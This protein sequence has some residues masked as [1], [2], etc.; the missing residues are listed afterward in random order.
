MSM[1]EAQ[2][3]AYLQALPP[4]DPRRG[5]AFDR[6]L[7]ARDAEAGKNDQAVEHPSR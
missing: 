4:G 6:W 2:A 7:D 1:T 3:R 5:P